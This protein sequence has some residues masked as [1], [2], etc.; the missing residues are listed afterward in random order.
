MEDSEI[1]ENLE[2]GPF[3]GTVS[4]TSEDVREFYESNSRSLSA[5]AVDGVARDTEDSLANCG[6]VWWSY[7]SKPWLPKRLTQAE[8]I[9]ESEIVE[10]LSTQDVLAFLH[11]AMR[12]E[13]VT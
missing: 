1:R 5:F 7:E 11:K 2:K 4:M 9:D 13:N 12:G 3:T 6:D 8:D 10:V